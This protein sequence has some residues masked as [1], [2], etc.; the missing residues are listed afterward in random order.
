MGDSTQGGD[1]KSKFKIEELCF[2]FPGVSFFLAI[3]L[4]MACL[5]IFQLN[6]PWQ[7]SLSNW[8]R[9]WLKKE[10]SGKKSPGEQNHQNFFFKGKKSF[11]KIMKLYL[12]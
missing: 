2:D 5:Y 9:G 4:V 12:S 7:A 11:K 8:M 10:T 1:G 6:L 3:F